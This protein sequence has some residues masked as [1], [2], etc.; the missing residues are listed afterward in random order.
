MNKVI[1]V[2]L[3]LFSIVINVNSQ[4]LVEWRGVNRTGIYPDKNLLKS[5]PEKG[6]ELVLE[7][8][9]IGTGYSSPVVYKNTIYVCGRRDSVDIISAI[10]MSG[11]KKW[12]KVYGKAWA[13]SYPET[14]CTPTIEND[15]IYLA[16]GM[17]EVVCIDALTGNIIWSVDAHGK[18]KGE[19]HNWGVSESL[20]IT[21]KAVFYVT[22]G[23]ETSV[24]ALNKT[25]GELIWNTKGLGGPRAYASSL[26][27]EKAGLKILIAQTARDLIG[28][29]V[30]NGEILWSYDLIQYHTGQRGK[31][32]NTNTPLYHNNEIFITSGYGHPALMFKLS[33][34]GRSISLKWQNV[35]FDNHMGGVVRIG[36]YLYG[37][38]HQNSVGKWLCLNWDS[39]E[40]KYE[41]LWNSKGPIISADNMLYCIDEKSGNIALVKPNPL[42]FELVSS[43]KNKKSAGPYWAHPAIFDGKLYDRHGD[44]LLVYNVK[45]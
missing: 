2:L 30:D 42:S 11:A 41:T 36:D 17:G 33:P 6:P 10:D 19:Y 5:W 18:Y 28:I 25:N 23:E 1:S 12:E 34:D 3:I 31:G 27:I 40:T 20:A 29:N 35:D 21:E 24:I 14:R 15:K 32:A 8:S 9:D 26:I 22:G 38:N 16:S 39:G 43:F 13:R 45:N 44:Y 7:I 37:S 4:S